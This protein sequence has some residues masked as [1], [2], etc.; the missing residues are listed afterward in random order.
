MTFL[1]LCEHQRVFHHI[2]YPY[3]RPLWDLSTVRDADPLASLAG[4]RAQLSHLSNQVHAFVHPAEHNV[5]K[6]QML[7]LLQG[8]VELGAVCV[9]PTVCHGQEARPCVSDVKVLIFKLSAID[10]LASSAVLVCDVASL[11]HRKTSGIR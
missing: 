4:R 7:S 3:H 5:F 2:S 6:V 11:K 8:D 1:L 10:G 9:S